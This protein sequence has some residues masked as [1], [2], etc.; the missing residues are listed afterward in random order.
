MSDMLPILETEYNI[1]PYLE[2]DSRIKVTLPP[3]ST[4]CVFLHR[5]LTSE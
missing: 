2:L 5:T 4:Y 1:I 3:R